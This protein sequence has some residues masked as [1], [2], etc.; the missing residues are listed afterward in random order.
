MKQ[1]RSALLILIFVLVLGAGVGGLIFLRPAAPELAEEPDIEAESST[2][3]EPPAT[4][5]VPPP[6]SP[7]P[8]PAV[9][10]GEISLPDGFP[11]RHAGFTLE[12]SVE[13]EVTAGVTSYFVGRYHGEDAEEISIRLLA[14]Q[15]KTSA[16]FFEHM[17]EALTLS[18]S[19]KKIADV[20]LP[21]HSTW[22]E[23]VLYS[24]DEAGIL[25]LS[26]PKALA[27]VSAPS[28]EIARLF[29]ASLKFVTE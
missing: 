1:K 26:H 23:A 8:A 19:V 27:V 2:V 13:Q 29:G 22:S 9:L 16:K 24:R 11:S 14:L 15:S 18:G 7:P 4:L 28:P 21:E 10:I 20:E 6:P 17:T 25:I 12:S 3:P 5:P